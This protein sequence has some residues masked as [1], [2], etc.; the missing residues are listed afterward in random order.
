MAGLKKAGA[1]ACAVALV[2]TG[3][4]FGGGPNRTLESEDE[5]MQAGQTTTAVAQCDQGESASGGGFRYL[6]DESLFEQPNLNGLYPLNKRSWM[7]EVDNGSGEERQLEAWVVCFRDAAFTRVDEVA[8]IEQ[9]E[10]ETIKAKCPK[11]TSV[12][13]G[14]LDSTGDFNE[15]FTVQT[16]P[17]GK[18]TWLVRVRPFFDGAVAAHAVCDSKAKYT[19]VEETLAGE[20]TRRTNT[21]LAESHLRCP[22]GHEATSGGYEVEDNSGGTASTMFPDPNDARSW[23]TTVRWIASNDPPLTAYVVCRKG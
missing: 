7:A 8:T 23:F 13:G 10:P 4:A 6:D 21:D 19:V 3:S 12:A 5:T 9:D 11:G 15:N 17:Q 1:L 14:G 2:A 22:R 20:T 16:R 18:R